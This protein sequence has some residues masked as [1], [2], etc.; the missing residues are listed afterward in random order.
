MKKISTLPINE[1]SP[2]KQMDSNYDMPFCLL[3]MLGTPETLGKAY[4][5]VQLLRLSQHEA[6]SLMGHKIRPFWG[7]G[8]GERHANLTMTSGPFED[9]KILIAFCIQSVFGKGFP[10]SP[11]ALV[12][13]PPGSKAPTSFPPPIHL[14]YFRLEELTLLLSLRSDNLSL[15][16][17]SS[18]TL[19]KHHSISF[20]NDMGRAVQQ[21]V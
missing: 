13:K 20:K 10:L 15:N 4:S 1:L 21:P 5:Y 16:Y 14:F 8:V 18:L 7:H 11:R 9:G 12:A 2:R 19:M 3:D 6:P 17:C